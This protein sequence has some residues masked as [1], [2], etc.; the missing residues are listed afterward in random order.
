MD[1]YIWQKLTKCENHIE[2]VSSLVCFGCG[3]PLFAI[4]YPSW[5]ENKFLLILASLY[6]L[7]PFPCVLSIFKKIKLNK[8]GKQINLAAVLRAIV[9]LRYWSNGRHLFLEYPPTTS[10]VCYLI[11]NNGRNDT[12][13]L[14]SSDFCVFDIDLYKEQKENPDKKEKKK[15]AQPIMYIFD[16][17]GE[18]VYWYK[19]ISG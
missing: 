16:N 7:Y 14:D 6:I 9:P 10:T 19:I 17:E 13:L 3:L 1:N 2:S 18:R 15:T 11:F 4:E 8:T 12:D 5:T